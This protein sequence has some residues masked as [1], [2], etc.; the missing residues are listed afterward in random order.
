MDGSRV[1]CTDS[2][3]VASGAF[4]LRLGL[5]VAGVL[6]GVDLGLFGIERLYHNTS[7]VP[8]LV[9]TNTSG[10]SAAIR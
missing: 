2:C 5:E 10:I 1:G 3:D 8:T 7:V 9:A 4:R 6:A